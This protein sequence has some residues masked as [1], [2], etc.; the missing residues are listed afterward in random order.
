MH[1]RSEDCTFG[2]E[3]VNVCVYVCVLC[4]LCSGL[5]YII[6]FRFSIR[7]SGASNVAFIAV[8]MHVYVYGVC[9][10]FQFT[11]YKTSLRH[12]RMV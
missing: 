7:I 9:M 12:V 10:D 4:S 8:L 11:K 3:T 6:K 5:G 2:T 1:T